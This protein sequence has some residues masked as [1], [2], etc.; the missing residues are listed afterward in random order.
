MAD[1]LWL[2]VQ[3]SPSDT[4]RVLRA[5]RQRYISGAVGEEVGYYFE[6]DVEATKDTSN[7][8]TI[9]FA[10]MH[11]MGIAGDD[12][13]ERK[14]TGQM[15][16][17]IDGVDYTLKDWDAQEGWYANYMRNVWTTVPGLD[18]NCKKS[19]LTRNQVNNARIWV[20]NLGCTKWTPYNYMTISDS[21]AA[22]YNFKNSGSFVMI[23][24]EKYYPVI[25]N[26]TGVDRY[27]I[28]IGGEKY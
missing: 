8:Y 20:N 11:M 21:A 10:N 6:W 19:G 26:G 1:E 7:S 24:N 17:T 4:K 12:I 25:G 18:S 16:I 2:R 28:Q 22:G 13:D 23:G 14:L 5:K 15:G 3:E 9:S 27:N